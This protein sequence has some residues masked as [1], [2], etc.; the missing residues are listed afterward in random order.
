MEGTVAGKI[1]DP[2][3]LPVPPGMTPVA[4]AASLF[5]SWESSLG[6]GTLI[7]TEGLRVEVFNAGYPLAEVGLSLRGLGRDDEV[8]FEIA[9]ELQQLPRGTAAA[10]EIPSYMIPTPMR[11]LEVVLLR[12]AFGES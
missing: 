9:E 8:V 11:R 4:D 12:A 6:G 3:A 5:F 2:R 7:G 10:I 1:R